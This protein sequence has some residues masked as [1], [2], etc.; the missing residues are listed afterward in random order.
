MSFKKKKGEKISIGLLKNKGFPCS[1]SGNESTYNAGDPSLIPRSGRSPRKDIVYPLQYSWTSL[2]AQMV[3]NPPAMQEAWVQ[4]LVWED[5]LDKEK[6]SSILTW[7]ISWAAVHRVTKSL[8]QL[9]NLHFHL[10][11]EALSFL[12]TFCYLNGYHLHI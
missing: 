10:H 6:S 12:F 2:V 8:T 9:S 4:S 7:R 1:S 5:P 3:K 11:Q